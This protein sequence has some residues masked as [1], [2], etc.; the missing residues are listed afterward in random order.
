MVALLFR[1]S[2]SST[3]LRV[4]LLSTTTRDFTI[5]LVLYYVPEPLRVISG[6]AYCML[7]VVEVMYVVSV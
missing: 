3:K 2:I 4:V 1:V 5:K 6:S 7:I